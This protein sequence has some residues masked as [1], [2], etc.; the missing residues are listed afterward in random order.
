METEERQS[1]RLIHAKS[2]YLLQHAYNPVDWYEWSPEAFE[3]ATRENKPIFL[4]IGYSCCHWCHVMENESFEDEEVA[5]LLNENYVAIKVDREERPDID[6]IY[7]T[8]CQAMTGQG[9]WP[10]T[11]IMT[12]DQRPFFAGTYFSKENI[13]KRMG[14]VYILETIAKRWNESQE[15]VVEV[16]EKVTCFL[17]EPEA[18]EEIHELNEEPIMDGYRHLAAG[19]NPIFGGFSAAPLFPSPHQMMFLLRYWHDTKEDH[20][21]GMVEQTLFSMYKGGIYDHVGGGFA[22]Y[23]T[24]PSWLIPHF[25]KMLYDNALL[26]MLYSE[27]YQATKRPLFQEVAQGIVSFIQR[28]MTHPKGGFYSAIDADAEGVEGKYYVWTPEQVLDVLGEEDGNWW[29][30]HYGITGNGNFEGNSIP[31]LIGLDFHLSAAS[32]QQA[33][34]ISEARLLDMKSRLLEARQK[35]PAPHKDD[36]ILTSWNALMIAALAR[37]GAVFQREDWLAMAERALRFIH[38]NL[39][40]E[41]DCRLLARYREDDAAHLAFIDD[42]AFMI[43]ASLELYEATSQQSYLD[44]ARAYSEETWVLFR[45]EVAGG[46]FFNP[47]DGEELIIRPKE[48][49]D[50]AMP[51]GNGVILW[52]WMRL[53]KYLGDPIW[54][55]RAVQILKTRM[56]ELQAHATPYTV[57][58]MALQ[59]HFHQGQEVVL[60]GSEEDSSVLE[61]M[62][63]VM[64]VHFLPHHIHFAFVT[65]EKGKPLGDAVPDFL[66]EY[67]R[68]YERKH[69]GVT[70]YVC[71]NYSCQD[72]VDTVDQLVEMLT[73]NIE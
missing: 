13:G 68:S 12:P 26:L 28:E 36:K 67:L 43:W 56:D 1:N 69:D 17:R 21:L 48:W 47:I 20:A 70:A 45:D 4:S 71:E 61:E 23:S 46:F 52:Q 40:R 55:E 24:D 53:S 66:P 33:L 73:S 54:Q 30:H 31:N 50:G 72:P 29:N 2:P 9:G 19:F 35:R 15:K 14:L 63:H 6:Q 49:Y 38:K 5:A 34:E 64:A 16:A 62:H 32:V 59:E 10:L 51:S 42:Y 41:E 44:L 37:A 65:N 18:V 3:K 11:I 25:E 27:A 39:V 58:L 8:V 60:I 7:M 57:S 22:R